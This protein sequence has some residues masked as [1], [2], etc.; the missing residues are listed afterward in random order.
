MKTDSLVKLE[1]KYVANEI[2]G[3]GLRGETSW[4]RF[5]CFLTC[6]RTFCGEVVAVGGDFSENYHFQY[7]PQTEEDIEFTDTNFRAYLMHPAPPMVSIPK[8]LN[9]RS[10][11]HLR[12]AFE[13]YWSDWG[14]CANRLRIVTEYLLD[15]LGIVR[16]G[17]KGKRKKAR[18]DLADRIELLKIAQPGHD[19]LLTAL[20]LVGNLG[21]HGDDVEFN[22][23]IDCFE[24]LEEA[25]I[26]LLDGRREKIVARARRIITAK[27]KPQP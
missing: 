18:L 7:N 1:P 13:L 21:S 8:S 5:H 19:E 24:F 22:D 17:P 15:Q 2:N 25:M 11:K 9:D 12:H 20:R 6:T 23:L 27:G 14:A 3:D 4:G 16:E 10:K 26:E